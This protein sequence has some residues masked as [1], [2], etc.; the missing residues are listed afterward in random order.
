MIFMG[1]VCF[2]GSRGEGFLVE[3][4][5]HLARRRGRASGCGRLGLCNVHKSTVHR[6]CHRL[7]LGL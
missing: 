6:L 1:L 5:R 2:G 4:T 3:S 7:E